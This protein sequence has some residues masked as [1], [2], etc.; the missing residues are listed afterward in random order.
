MEDYLSENNLKADLVA[1]KITSPKKES[2]A[3][4]ICSLIR[5]ETV[6]RKPRPHD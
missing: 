2:R 5:F 4:S 6:T 1:K 3:E